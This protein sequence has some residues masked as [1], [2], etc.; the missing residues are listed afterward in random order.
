MSRMEELVEQLNRYA[1][2]YY[3]LDNPLISDGQYDKLYDELAALEKAENIVLPSSPTRRIGGEPVKEFAEH[4]HLHKLYSLDKRNSFEELSAWDEKIK[5]AAER[6]VE[7][8]LEYKL[9]GLT[10]CLT[11]EDGF[12]RCASTRGNGTIGEEVTAQVSTVKSIPLEIPF[13]GVLEVQGEGIMRL[14]ALSE[15]NKTAKE[16]LKNAR[17]GVAGAIRNLDPKVTAQRKLDI[18]FYNVNYKR[19]G[20][21]KLLSSQA[22]CIEFLRA[23]RFKTEMLFCSENMS[24]IID[25]ISAVDKNRLDFLIDGMVVKVNDFAL[26]DKLGYTD[27]FP[28]WAMAYKFEAEEAVTKLKDVVWQVGRTGKLTPLGKLEPV[29]LCGA[30]IQKATLNNYGDIRRKGI[31]I[32]ATV[33]IRRSNDVI[34][35]I[36][37]I[38]EELDGKDVP[39]PETCP[40]CGAEL[41]ENGAHIFC[42]NEYGCKPQ[43][44]GRIE[45][46]CSKGCMDID[47]VSDKTIERLYDT[48]GVRSVTDLY[49]LDEEGLSKIDGFKKK[50]IS[51]FLASVE[52]S[53]QVKLGSFINALGIPNVG[54]KTAED[55]AESFKS[56]DALAAADAQSLLEI[57]EVGEIVAGSIVAF[58]EKH[59]E[60]VERFKN[61][62]I[63]PRFEERNVGGVFDGLKVV[64]T[65][66]IS[67]PRD[68][69]AKIIEERGGKVQSAVTKDTDLVIAGEDA[70]SK[71]EK[72]RKLGVKIIDDNEFKSLINS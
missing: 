53:K 72:A 4:K 60:I 43:V 55:L 66:K 1:Y 45:H 68:A 14:S 31:K 35:E 65:G 50:K 24:E 51:N 10:L 18:I 59:G 7:Y 27:K 39:V 46:F 57:D 5:K 70:G 63:N 54:R 13:K 8:T 67:M 16:P 37:G 6:E 44:C 9:D 32:G 38:A 12:F 30:T 56:I 71:L 2:H 22:E 49:F 20:D 25:K 36:L 42:P 33:F 40:A 19:G 17:N 29:E 61:L 47:G 15:Y 52:N 62:G 11:Y 21:G 58:F 34:P 41:Y 69:A 26:R 48:L 28:R 23:N 3:V 64:L